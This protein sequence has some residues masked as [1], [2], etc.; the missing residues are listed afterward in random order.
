MAAVLLT[1]GLAAL[2]QGLR[3]DPAFVEYNL[4]TNKEA[5]DPLE[6]STTKN[7]SHFPS[8]SDWRFPFYT[9]FLDRL[10]DGNPTNNDINGTVYEQDTFSNQL[11]HGGDLQGLVDSLDY[12]QGMGM[13]VGN[14]LCCRLLE[15]GFVANILRR[16][17]I[18][19]DPRS[20]TFRGA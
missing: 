7:S 16:R 10:A 6:Y 9:I 11:R 15:C 18:L 2:V 8:P 12:I 17:F 20:S 19:P 3:Y 13:K 5:T 4:N 14:G 1:I